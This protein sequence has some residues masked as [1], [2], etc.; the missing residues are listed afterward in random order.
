MGTNVALFFL[1]MALGAFPGSSSARSWKGMVPGKTTRQQVIDKFGEANRS[2]SKGGELSDGLSYQ[3]K[4]AIPGAVEADFFFDKN[5]VL[6]RIDV[7]PARRLAKSDILRVYGDKYTERVTP[8]GHTY[9]DYIQEGLVVFFH[10]D[11]G[12]VTTL[13]YTAPVREA[14]REKAR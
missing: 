11:T 3:G 4:Q 7:F 9:F 6:F 10:K 12:E 2:F 14:A 8:R 1:V 5:G 13:T